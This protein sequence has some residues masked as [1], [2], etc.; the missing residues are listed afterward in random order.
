[1]GAEV[2]LSLNKKFGVKFLFDMRGFW[3]DEKADG[4]AWNT[5]KWF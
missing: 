5:K 2:G 1:M 3:A 4:G